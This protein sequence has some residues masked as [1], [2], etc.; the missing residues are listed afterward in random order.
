MKREYEEGALGRHGEGMIAAA[1]GNRLDDDDDDDGPFLIEET[2]ADNE[3]E[4]GYIH[5]YVHMWMCVS[6]ILYQPRYVWRQCNEF[7]PFPGP[8]CIIPKTVFTLT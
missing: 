8:K 7:R 2:T 1:A 3:E 5:T 6:R 4:K